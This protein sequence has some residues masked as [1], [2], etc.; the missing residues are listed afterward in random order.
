M[1]DSYWWLIPTERIKMKASVSVSLPVLCFACFVSLVLIDD[2]FCILRFFVTFDW[3]PQW[4]T[5]ISVFIQQSISRVCLTLWLS[6]LMMMILT[7]F[8]SFQTSMTV[9]INTSPHTWLTINS[10]LS[11]WHLSG[12]SLWPV[13]SC[14]CCCVVPMR[15][16]IQSDD[17]CLNHWF[18]VWKGSFRKSDVDMSRLCLADT[19]KMNEKHEKRIKMWRSIRSKSEMLSPS[20]IGRFDISWALQKCEKWKTNTRRGCTCCRLA[21]P[22]SL[23]ANLFFHF[24]FFPF[25]LQIFYFRIFWINELF[26][27]FET[28]CIKF[29]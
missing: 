1:F 4:I 25:F 27:F 28:I 16:K 9:W 8:W 17:R 11:E 26:N 3:F 19:R 15:L 12:T 24:T 23:S 2:G 13:L 10:R 14:C 6:R 21:Q 20:L 18:R 22:S 7:M 29:E 5:L